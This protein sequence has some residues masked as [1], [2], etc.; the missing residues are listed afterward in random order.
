MLS[1]SDT[2]D[3]DG[4]EY[5]LAVTNNGFTDIVVDAWLMEA[6]YDDSPIPVLVPKLPLKMDCT[7]VKDTPVLS[8]GIPRKVVLFSLAGGAGDGSGGYKAVSV[9]TRDAYGH[10]L[11]LCTFTA[12][13]GPKLW[14]KVAFGSAGQS[15]WF[16]VVWSGQGEYKGTP[17]L[18]VRR[19]A[20]P[21]VLV[22]SP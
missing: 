5:L 19:E 15:R 8:R 7:G 10:G 20:G 21:P 17:E 6:I 11:G 9:G 12:S 13:T 2:P 14:L 4:S 22:A 3:R 16:S 1:I 18:V